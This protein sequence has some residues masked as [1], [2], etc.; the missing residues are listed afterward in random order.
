MVG[1][2]IIGGI[3]DLGPTGP[4][5][6]VGFGQIFR[7]DC[8]IKVSC[9]GYIN[10]VWV[11]FGHNILIAV[12]FGHCS[13]GRGSS[14]ARSH[15]YSRP[16]LTRRSHTWDRCILVGP[17]QRSD[18]VKMGEFTDKNQHIMVI[19]IDS[20]RVASSSSSSGQPEATGLFFYCSLLGF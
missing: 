12:W 19:I 5:S 10:W 11:V 18:N 17:I 2:Q 8:L 3:P 7:N 9:N 6:W 15:L 16:L 20:H 1:Y 14:L 4:M 13:V